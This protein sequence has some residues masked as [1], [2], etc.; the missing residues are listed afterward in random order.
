MIPVGIVSIFLIIL[1]PVVVG[2]W[3][4][5][6]LATAACMLIMIVL[7]AGELAAVLQFLLEIYRKK[8]SVWQAF[9][10]GGIPRRDIVPLGSRDKR[11]SLGVSL[12]LK[13]VA[14]AAV[15]VWTMFRPA[16]LDCMEKWR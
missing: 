11:I 2:T 14:S 4:S 16:V 15:G 1:Q 13:L 12:L 3:C 8:D 9:W 7:T 5:W 6:C 10:K